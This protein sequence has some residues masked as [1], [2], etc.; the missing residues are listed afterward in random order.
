MKITVKA[1]ANIA[2]IK[3]WGKKDP[4][5]RLPL[6]SSIS[7]NLSNVFTLTTVEFLSE[8]DGDEIEMEGERIVGKEAGRIIT[9]LN[10]VRKLAGIK[11]KARVKTKNNFPKGTGVAS[12][13]SG[14][15]ALTLAATSAAGLDLSEKELSVLARLGSGSACRSIP[16]GFVEWK[17]GKSS[18]TSYAQMIFS[19][20]HWDIRDIVVIVAAKEKKVSS[21]EGHKLALTSPF[22]KQ[23]I[24]N[25]PKKIEEIRNA[26]KKRNFSGFG[27]IVE[28]EA[29]NMHAV[30]MTSEP[31]LFYWLPKTL[32]VIKAVREWREKGINAYFTIDAGP[33][34]HIICQGKDEKRIRKRL[35]NIAGIK[36]VIVNKPARGAHLIN[37]HLF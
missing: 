18:Q 3:Y 24:K 31:P 13:A 27:E 37:K 20:K 33:N 15:A 19:P 5:L 21:T 6:N 23:R 1:P 9:H 17:K 32:E 4:N 34:V 28:Q 36:K 35:K 10:R 7:M 26:L 8:L 16:D 22:F 25:L 12:S 2:F 14:F 11:F 29:I 30:M